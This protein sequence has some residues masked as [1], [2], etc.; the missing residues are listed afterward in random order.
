MDFATDAIIDLWFGGQRSDPKQVAN[1]YKLWFKGGARLD[2]NIRERFG[3]L[4]ASDASLLGAASNSGA[5]TLDDH[6]ALIISLD[7][8]PRHL[9]RGT[10]RAF[11][12]SEPAIS[13][14]REI[15][16]RN[17]WRTLSP[18]EQVF[19]LMPLHHSESIID[20]TEGVERLLR[21]QSAEKNGWQTLLG[22]FLRS[23]QDHAL[24]VQQ[25]GRFPHR[26][27]IMGRPSTKAEHAFLAK[28]PQSFG[29]MHAD[30]RSPRTSSHL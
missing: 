29:Q 24:I 17:D 6:L 18:A 22:R 15:T 20:Q 13:L 25:I 11:A 26:N 4:F 30:R 5:L 10:P 9:F 27:E 14:S 7:Q 1:H 28:N 3:Y 2:Q 21:L 8:F 19:T 16:A 23:F 12:Y